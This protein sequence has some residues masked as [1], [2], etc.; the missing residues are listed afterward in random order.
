MLHKKNIYIKILIFFK[1]L[2]WQEK[3]SRIVQ[4]SI[5]PKTKGFFFKNN[6]N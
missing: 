5:L 4:L 1:K 3:L 6:V 2:K